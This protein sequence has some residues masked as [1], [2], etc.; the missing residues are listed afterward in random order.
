MSRYPRY[1]YIVLAYMGALVACS[2]VATVCVCG[3]SLTDSF[4][5]VVQTLWTVGYGDIVPPHESG[6]ILSSAIILLGTVGI[7]SALGVVGGI[8][9][10]RHTDRHAR[11]ESELEEARARNMQA[12]Y[13][14]GEGKGI[15]RDRIDR[16]VEEI[17][18]EQR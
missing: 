3:F 8:V 18:N 6:M 7:T 9:L 15:D 2:T 14:W 16:V 5:F 13:R 17:R 1:M 4:Y 11:L 12:L 10:D